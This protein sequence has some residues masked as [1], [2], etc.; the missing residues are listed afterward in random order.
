VQVVPEAADCTQERQQA[1]YRRREDP[2]LIP[3][4]SPFRLPILPLLLPLPDVDG[5]SVPLVPLCGIVVTPLPGAQ[6]LQSAG[7][8]PVECYWRPLCFAVRIARK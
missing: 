5:A 8:R 4:R 1:G 3:R 2:R 7:L 6:F